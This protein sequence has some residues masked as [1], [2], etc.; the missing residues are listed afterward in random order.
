[1]GESLV[2]ALGIALS[3]LPILAILLFLAR[4]RPSLTAEA[5]S[6]AWLGAVAG[7]TLVCVFVVDWSG[8]TDTDPAWLGVTE[9]VV[10]SGFFVLAGRI[11]LSG[12]Q[13]LGGGPPAWV[14]VLDRLGPLQAA[15]LA[16][17]LSC[18]NPKNLALF[19][20]G[21]VL[22]VDASAWGGELALSAVV[23]VVVAAA[24]VFGPFAVYSVFPS[25]LEG[26]LASLRRGLVRRGRVIAMVLSVVIGALFVIEGIRAL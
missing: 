22:M 20:G 14:G 16:V 23:F 17:L 3:P 10:G 26:P 21:A 1:V 4:D 11:A 12:E 24:G 5:F 8:V 15:A 18:G 7:A 25:R 6:L 13:A 2:L 19:L 9:L